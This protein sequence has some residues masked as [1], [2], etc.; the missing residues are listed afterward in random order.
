[1][2]GEFELRAL[3]GTS[4][5][6]WLRAD[7]WIDFCEG[8]MLQVITHTKTT[9]HLHRAWRLQ[10]MN[11]NAVVMPTETQAKSFLYCFSQVLRVSSRNLQVIMRIP[12]QQLIGKAKETYH[13][14]CHKVSF[15]LRK[16][17]NPAIYFTATQ[18]TS[19]L[20]FFI[21]VQESLHIHHCSK[22]WGQ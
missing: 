2:K 8:G 13:I 1:M 12:Q 3:F 16:G 15:S 18:G 21:I 17:N 7:F 22:P 6:F 19:E 4:C 10:H 5:N 9:N 20:L 14:D 11:G